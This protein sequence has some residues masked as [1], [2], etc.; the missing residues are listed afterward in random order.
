MATVKENAV[1][2]KRLKGE[3]KDVAGVV[4]DLTKLLM[5]DRNVPALMAHRGKWKKVLEKLDTI[6]QEE[7]NAENTKDD[8]QADH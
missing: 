2:I 8:D 5:A 6:K 1:E 4:H 3:I 7:V